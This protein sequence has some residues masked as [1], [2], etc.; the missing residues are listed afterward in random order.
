LSWV[1]G[2]LS[3]SFHLLNSYLPM[4]KKF[5]LQCTPRHPTNLHE[6]AIHLIASTIRQAMQEALRFGLSEIP[7][8]S[9]G[10]S[11]APIRVV[12]ATTFFI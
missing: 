7:N 10:M 6:K 12:Q 3:S 1:P 8:Q 9:F 4:A 11:L 2:G 5:N